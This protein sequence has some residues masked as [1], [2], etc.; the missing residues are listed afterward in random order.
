MGVVNNKC[1]ACPAGWV[2]AAGDDPTQNM[3]TACAKPKNAL[4]RSGDKLCEA[5]QHVQNHE[6]VACLPG[7]TSAGGDDPHH[8]DTPC[9]K[10]YCKIHEHVV[11]HKCVPCTAPSAAG[12]H[13]KD[14]K[15]AG[16]L[17]NKAGDDASGP[18]TACYSHTH[19]D[20]TNV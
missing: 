5:G 20:M 6:C 2:R 19:P 12:D 8:H 18:D 1:V 10:I 3:D 13:I 15:A 16:H 11:N 7:W 4:Q 14:G 17:M 9:Q